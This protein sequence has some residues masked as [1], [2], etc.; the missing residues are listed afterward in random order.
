MLF[1][2]KWQFLFRSS[3]RT[4]EESGRGVDDG[5][6]TLSLLGC[7]TLILVLVHSRRIPALFSILS[8]YFGMEFVPDRPF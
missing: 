2:L 1:M 7:A 6:Y 4:A 5:F 3:G 8:F